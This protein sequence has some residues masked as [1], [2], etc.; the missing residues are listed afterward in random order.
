MI[1]HGNAEKLRRKAERF[2]CTPR[3]HRRPQR[4][5]RSPPSGLAAGPILAAH[6]GPSPKPHCFPFTHR[7]WKRSLRE[8]GG[9][10]QQFG[11]HFDY[12][13]RSCIRG[14]CVGCAPQTAT[15]IRTEKYVHFRRH[16]P[17]AGPHRDIVQ[18]S[19][20]LM[21]LSKVFLKLIYSHKKGRRR[22]QG[23]LRL[24]LNKFYLTHSHT[25]RIFCTG[26][27]RNR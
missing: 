19:Q 10:L 11:G 9:S 22:A 20:T 18:L 16:S 2:P 13:P 23:A 26:F 24:S 6:N 1:R 15:T 17:F 14:L 4:A 5:D 27:E 12:R 21:E 7:T 8:G 3:S 25:F